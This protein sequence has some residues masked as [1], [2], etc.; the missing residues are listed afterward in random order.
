M[1]R[2]TQ[3]QPGGVLAPT[4]PVTMPRLAGRRVQCGGGYGGA[5]RGLEGWAV[6]SSPLWGAGHRGRRGSVCQ[7]PEA[8]KAHLAPS[9]GL[10]CSLGLACTGES[11]WPPSK[12]HRKLTEGVSA[13]T[14]RPWDTCPCSALF[15]P[16]RPRAPRGDRLCHPAPSCWA[17][18]RATADGEPHPFLLL[19][20]A[21]PSASS[22]PVLC[23]HARGPGGRCALQAAGTGPGETVSVSGKGEKEG[24]AG[25]STC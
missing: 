25:G 17:G 23:P 15:L 18:T 12:D 2:E 1:T 3:R 6:N 8:G 24:R 21:G 13:V 9:P 11:P 22:G 20:P 4:P 10:A 14:S 16:H 19:V 7:G 5:Q